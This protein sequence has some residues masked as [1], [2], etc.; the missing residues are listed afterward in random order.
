MQKNQLIIPLLL[1]CSVA[2][3]RQGEETPVASDEPQHVWK[4]QV[5]ALDKAKQVEQ[6]LMDAHQQRNTGEP[7]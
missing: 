2:C 7:Q 4:E 6:T 1:F 3:S 5:Q